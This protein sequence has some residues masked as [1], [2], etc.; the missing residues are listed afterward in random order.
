MKMCE[1]GEHF[2]NNLGKN[3]LSKM[4][5]LMERELNDE[6]GESTTAV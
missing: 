3:G 1:R 2:K 6:R 4:R 5:M